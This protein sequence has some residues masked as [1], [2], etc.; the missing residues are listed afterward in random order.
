MAKSLAKQGSALYK[1]GR[2]E[3][4]IQKLKDSMLE[5]RD[6]QTLTLLNKV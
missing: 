6:K 4:A 3:E 5:Y 2:Y 1:L